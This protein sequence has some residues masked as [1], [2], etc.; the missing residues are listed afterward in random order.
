[1]QHQKCREDRIAPKGAPMQKLKRTLQICV[2]QEDESE[3]AMISG[4]LSE[5][6]FLSVV[7]LNGMLELLSFLHENESKPDVILLGAELVLRGGAKMLK[8]MSS[9]SVL[10]KVPIV[11]TCRSDYY[12]DAIREYYQAAVAENSPDRLP[13]RALLKPFSVAALTM[14]LSSM[15]DFFEQAVQKL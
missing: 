14:V 6:G 1:M 13:E 4:I 8:Q 11:F 3:A 7:V 15:A 9:D 5:E 12:G 2:V 10:P